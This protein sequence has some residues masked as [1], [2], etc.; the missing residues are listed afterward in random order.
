MN[1]KL[2][3][4]PKKYEFC[5][6]FVYEQNINEGTELNDLNYEK[7]DFLKKKISNSENHVSLNFNWK[8]KT[9]KL[10]DHPPTYYLR[11]IDGILEE[12]TT[13]CRVK[14]ITLK[15]ILD[16][17]FTEFEI[18]GFEK[19]VFKYNNDN[20][21]LTL[22]IDTH[23]VNT[24]DAFQITISTMGIIYF[25]GFIKSKMDLIKILRYTNIYNY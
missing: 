21:N 25:S 7:L 2:Y 11:V 9:Y 20:N 8:Q 18:D 12:T 16:L 4:I 5:E 10:G 22:E 13:E 17:G 24:I 1:N 6:G 15:D 14:Y 19:R 3:Y 23:M